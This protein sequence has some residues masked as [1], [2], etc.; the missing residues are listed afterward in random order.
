MRNFSIRAVILALLAAVPASAGDRAG[1]GPRED[2]GA[3]MEAATVWV[4]VI[5]PSKNGW[6][7]GSGF[8]VA[9]GHVMTNAHV[10]DGMDDKSFILVVNDR[11]PLVRATVKA[12]AR[13]DERLNFDFALLTLAP[14]EGVAVP[15]TIPALPSLAFSLDVKRMDRVAAWG[16]PGMIIVADERHH[17][18]FQGDG[19]EAPPVVFT[20][21]TVS[22]L[23]R[24]PRPHVIHS[25]SIARGNSGGPLVNVRG[26][27]VGI[28]TWGASEFEG[29]GGSTFNAALAAEDI[30]AFLRA[31]GVVPRMAPPRGAL[32]HAGPSGADKTPP[33]AEARAVMDAAERGDAASQLLAGI[34]YAQGEDGFPQDLEQAIHWLERAAKNGGEFEPSARAVLGVALIASE[35]PRRVREGLR[36]LEFAADGDT[37]AD[38]DY[39]ALLARLHVYGEPAGLAFDAER[40][41]RYARKA[42]ERGHADGHAFLAWHTYLELIE[43]GDGDDATLAHVKRALAVDGDHALANAVLAHL[44]FDGVA[45]DEDLAKSRA[46]ARAA[47]DED[48]PFAELA[49]A[50]LALAEAD[51]GDTDAD[52]AESLRADAF[53]WAERAAQ[54]GDPLGQNLLGRMYLDG[55]GVDADP[56][57]AWVY[58]KL[59]AD[60]GGITANA[61]Y[62]AADD[63]DEE[64][65]GEGAGDSLLDRAEKTMTPAQLRE[66][67]R[68][69]RERRVE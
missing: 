44:Y 23:V 18:F 55:V 46:L 12:V 29:G 58:L 37:D 14:A 11:L 64:D 67:R 39:A 20:E 51:D 50:Y 6:S 4:V 45:V 24:R 9:D 26:E 42:A 57:E 53:A 59:G 7:T 32:P 36:H 8:F 61:E 35:E 5:H 43:D 54:N 65:E 17:D 15:V 38:G 34:G 28:N 22:T 68:R 10:V 56:L 33:G 25:A 48:E 40:S 52:E 21:G 62:A 27:V 69:Y 1:P 31:N 19:V 13:R 16:Y 47:A 30:V 3:L 66:A 41:Q 2:V 63:D 60:K 49:L